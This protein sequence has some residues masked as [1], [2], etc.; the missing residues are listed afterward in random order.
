MIVWISCALVLMLVICVPKYNFSISQHEVIDITIWRDLNTMICINTNVLVCM[1]R[2]MVVLVS[3]DFANIEIFIPWRALFRIW[4]LWHPTWKGKYLSKE[5]RWR[6]RLLQLLLLPGLSVIE[7][8]WKLI[9]RLTHYK[10][11]MVLFWIGKTIKNIS[12][13]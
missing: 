7:L 6:L 8:K 5:E 1:I 12:Y 3:G 2:L 11:K 9:R 4:S 10:R 13:D